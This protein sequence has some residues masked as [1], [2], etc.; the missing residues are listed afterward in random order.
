M[1]LKQTQL[2]FLNILNYLALT[3]SLLS[4]NQSF[5]HY[6]NNSIKKLKKKVEQKLKNFAKNWVFELNFEVYL[7]QNSTVSLMCSNANMKL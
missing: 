2:Q 4:N 5:R 1:C 6:I 3:R 7:S